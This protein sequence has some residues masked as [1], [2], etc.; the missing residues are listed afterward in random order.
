VTIEPIR[1]DVKV[2]FDEPMPCSCKSLAAKW[3][4]IPDTGW[5]DGWQGRHYFDGRDCRPFDVVR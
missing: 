2:D 1:S 4:Q 3:D 5:I